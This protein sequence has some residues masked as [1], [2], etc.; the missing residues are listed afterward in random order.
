ML[1]VMVSKYLQFNA[2]IVFIWTGI[3]VLINMKQN[4]ISHRPS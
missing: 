1:K 2:E 4:A 3:K